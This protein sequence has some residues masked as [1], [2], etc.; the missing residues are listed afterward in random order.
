MITTKKC[1]ALCAVGQTCGVVKDPIGDCEVVCGTCDE[2]GGQIC[3]ASK[4][5][6]CNNECT[7]KCGVI[8]PSTSACPLTCP[9]CGPN[10]QCQNNTCVCPQ[11]TCQPNQCG[12]GPCGI[13]CSCPTG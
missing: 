2:A 6:S 7:S 8:R 4:Q 13:T 9:S 11:G 10:F 3:N 12:P 5:C 1:A